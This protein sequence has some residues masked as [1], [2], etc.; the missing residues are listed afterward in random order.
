M[1]FFIYF[2]FFNFFYIF[3]SFW[4]F[5]SIW[6]LQFI[7]T[8]SLITT[9]KTT[10]GESSCV[11]IF[12]IARNPSLVLIYLSS[13]LFFS[14]TFFFIPLFWNDLVSILP[15]VAFFYEILHD[16]LIV[17]WILSNNYC[18]IICSAPGLHTLVIIHLYFVDPF[19]SVFTVMKNLSWRYI[20]VG[21]KE[22]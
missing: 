22:I 10:D 8:I 9:I 15:T 3:V 12:G 21:E 4:R 17:L 6:K 1:L 18:R 20:T 13:C 2:F 16:K 11:F 14:F 19:G 7:S 5:T